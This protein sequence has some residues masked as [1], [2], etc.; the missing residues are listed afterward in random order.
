MRKIFISTIMCLVFCSVCGI[1]Q[2]VFNKSGKS[3]NGGDP[4]GSKSIHNEF[5]FYI[6]FSE[7]IENGFFCD[8]HLGIS[9]GSNL[10]FEPLYSDLIVSGDRST[11][12]HYCFDAPPCKNGDGNQYIQ[13][14]LGLYCLDELGNFEIL[15]FCDNEYLVNYFLEDDLAEHNCVIQESLRF[16]LRCNELIGM[17]NLNDDRVIN[18]MDEK[19]K[20]SIFDIHGKVISFFN[21]SFLPNELAL[22][23]HVEVSGVY[24]VRIEGSNVRR[25]MKIYVV[26]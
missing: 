12:I 26:K 2:G 22:E 14:E 4:S 5:C 8:L 1:S 23:N 18:R 3:G 10:I 25:S 11:R 7:E 20:I 9:D 15:D 21:S 24:F 13:Y 19:F 17:G 6:N 16:E